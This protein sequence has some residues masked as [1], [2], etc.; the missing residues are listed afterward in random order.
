[1]EQ[2]ALGVSATTK[3]AVT[4][5]TTTP[6]LCANLAGYVAQTFASDFH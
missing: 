5:T 2:S 6:T 1:M 3:A 4:T